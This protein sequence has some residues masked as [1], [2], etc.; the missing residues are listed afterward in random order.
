[1]ANQINRT[2]NGGSIPALGF[3][4][5]ELMGKECVDAVEF[6][7]ETGYRHIDT[8]RFYQNED[9]I[10]KAVR[11]SRFSR[12]EVFITTKV[13]H[14][15]LEP[16]RFMKSV[17]NSLRSLDM[18][19]VDLLLVHW[20]TTSELQTLKAVE[21]LN[22]CLHKTYCRFAGVSNFNVSLMSKSLQLAPIVCNQTEYHPYLHIDRYLEFIRQND[23]VLTAYC[24]LAQGAVF[25]D[26]TMLN[27]AEKYKKSPAQI[28]IKWLLQQDNVAFIPKSGRKTNILSNFQVWD[29]DLSE[30]DF[31]AIHSLN[32]SMRLMNPSWACRWEE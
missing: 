31:Q 7:L 4:T 19:Y 20:P 27:L 28:A 24:P 17:E 18:D 13:W 30:E 8:A 3:G 12:E 29:F 10:G 5:Y 1:M 23:M 21:M 26:H 6:V 9:A 22:E 32:R 2:F 16:A 15:D 14:T 11:Q 25:K